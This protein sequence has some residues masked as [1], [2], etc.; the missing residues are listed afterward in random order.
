[1]DQLSPITATRDEPVLSA[2]GRIRV[3]TAEERKDII[4][5]YKAGKRPCW[6][7]QK[8]NATPGQ[9]AGLLNRARVKEGLPMQRFEKLPAS[10][11]PKVAAPARPNLH[12][13]MIKLANKKA[14]ATAPPPRVRLHLVESATA[15]TLMELEPHMCKWPTGLPGQSDFRYYGGNRIEGKPYCSGHAAMAYQP[16][17]RRGV[18]YFRMGSR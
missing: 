7:Q 12:P 14:E 10:D 2:N 8:Y 17:Q 15:V 9:I 16:P 13:V 5:S 18:G 3:W 11:R 6:L 4:E 1:M